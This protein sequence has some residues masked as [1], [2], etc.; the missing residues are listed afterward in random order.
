MAMADPAKS[1]GGVEQRGD[2]EE[3][4]SDRA[5]VEAGRAAAVTRAISRQLDRIEVA[6]GLAGEVEADDEVRFSSDTIGLLAQIMATH[7]RPEGEVE[8]Y[9]A[10]L[11]GPR[12]RLR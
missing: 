12:P 4:G 11:A 7:G 3:A 1:R 6:L 10:G 8:A 2:P 5:A 9:R